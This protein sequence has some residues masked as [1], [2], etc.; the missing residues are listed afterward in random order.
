MNILHVKLKMA[1]DI[2]CVSWLFI[3]GESV[4]NVRH[5]NKVIGAYVTVEAWVHLYHYLDRPQQRALYCDTD[6]VCTYN[7]MTK[8][9]WLKRGTVFGLWVRNWNR[10]FTLKISV[11]AGQ[12]LCLQNCR[13][14]D[15]Q[16]R[17]GVQGKRN[18]TE[19]QHLPAGQ[20][21]RHEGNDNE[22][23]RDRKGYSA[24]WTK[25]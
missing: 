21:R 7:L 8:L 13:S 1:P 10:A 9:L 19:L 18:N 17:G 5:S 20:F 23:G 16:S 12:N 25:D 11:A 3:A 14:P 4:P 6:S 24:H 22:R 2:I 15:R